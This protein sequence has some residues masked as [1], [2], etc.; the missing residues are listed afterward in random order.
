MANTYSAL[1]LHLVFSTKLRRKL[2]DP[3]IETEVWKYINGIA[4]KNGI[5]PIETGG[6]EDHIH[7]LLNYP[8]RYSASEIAKIIKAGSSGWFKRRFGRRS[9]GWQ[10]GYA[11]FS[12]SPSLVT[13][14]LRYIKSQREHH[15]GKSFEDEY[16]ELLDLHGIDVSDEKFLFG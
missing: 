11:A 5:K 2:I 15:Q 10:N 16:R 12:V 9:F 14:T 13:K 3:D 8:P 4:R 6:I 1:Y 7:S